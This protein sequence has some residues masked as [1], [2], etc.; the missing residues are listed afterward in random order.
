LVD[1][2]TGYNHVCDVTGR[3]RAGCLCH[4]RRYFFESLNTAPAEAQHVLD[5]IVEIYKIEREAA[6]RGI[7]GTEEHLRLR[8]SRSKPI[9]NRLKKW[10]DEQKPLHRPK[11]PIIRAIKYGL[12]QWDALIQFLD[13]PLLPPDNNESERR[14]RL[15]AQGRHAYL[16]AA[17]DQGAKNLATLMSLVVTCEVHGI[18]PEEYLADVLIRMNT[19]PM[20]RIDE[21]LPPRWKQLR[22]AERARE[23]NLPMHALRLGSLAASLLE[24][25]ANYSLSKA[26]GSHCLTSCQSG[27]SGS[28]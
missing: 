21:L 12:N 6:K 9:M 28:P 24:N 11:S 10:L 23:Q 8:Q 18:D 5:V 15:I 4:L 3:E 25:H 26:V 14:L 13:D 17:N 2:Y 1:G 20:S 19:H 27:P 22:D 7:V 16:F